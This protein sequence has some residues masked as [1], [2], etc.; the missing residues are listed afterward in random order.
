MVCCLSHILLD[1]LLSQLLCFV[2]PLHLATTEEAEREF[3]TMINKVSKQLANDVQLLQTGTM[4]KTEFLSEYGHLRPDT[5]SITSHRYDEAIDVYFG[6]NPSILSEPSLSEKSS[7]NLS[8]SSLLTDWITSNPNFFDGLMDLGLDISTNDLTNFLKLAVQS[9][10]MQN[11]N[12]A[13]V[14]HFPY[15]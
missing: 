11:L 4:T 8:E 12:S 3:F 5:Y 1:V 2:L 6:G 14:Y 13:K 7:H 15:S 10:K 9:L